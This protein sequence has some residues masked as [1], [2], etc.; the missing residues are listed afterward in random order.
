MSSPG[1]R[2]TLLVVA[3][4]VLALAAAGTG[5]VLALRGPAPDEVAEDYL[6]A[7]WAGDARTECELATEQWQHFLF[8]GRPYAGCADYA[9]AAEK[10]QRAGSGFAEY[11]EDTD[12][13]VTVETTAEGDGEARVAYALSFRYHGGDRAGFDALWQGASPQDRG[14]VL[15]SE[16]PDGWQVAGVDAG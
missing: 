7:Q 4:V 3:A 2:T 10:A 6:R 8:E 12:V 16:G 5:L 14:T 13:E 15:L 11:A 1:R 9:A